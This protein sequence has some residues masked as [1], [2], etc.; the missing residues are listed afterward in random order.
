MEPSSAEDGDAKDGIGNCRNAWGFNGAVL[1]RGR[2]R[3]PRPL[4]VPHPLTAS[5]EPSSAEDGDED[6]GVIVGTVVGLQWSRPQQRTE[7]WRSSIFGWCLLP[8]LQWSRPQQRTETTLPVEPP[9]PADTA[10][11]EPS[12]AEDGDNPNARKVVRTIVALQWSRPQ[13]RTETV[14]CTAGYAKSVKRFN[15][16]VLSRGRRPLSW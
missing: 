6:M 10:S 12:S 13:Q 9:A 4:G 3:S 11:M 5:M 7:T 15:G 1:S 2:R 16:A 14:R 8:P